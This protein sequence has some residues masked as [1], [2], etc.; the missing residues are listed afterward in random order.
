[1]GHVAYYMLFIKQSEKAPYCGT[2]IV[3]SDQH[4]ARRLIRALG[5]CC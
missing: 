1:M 3:S 2:D 5:I 4:N